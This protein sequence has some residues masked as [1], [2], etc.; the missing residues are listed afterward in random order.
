MPEKEKSPR[1]VGDI[2]KGI[3][4]QPA[5]L[6]PAADKKLKPPSVEEMDQPDDDPRGVI[7]PELRHISDR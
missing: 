3:P 5:C 4:P 2:T 7:R 6:E 1:F